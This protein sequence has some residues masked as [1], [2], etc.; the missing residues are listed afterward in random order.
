MR[1]VSIRLLG[2][3]LGGHL[4]WCATAT[5]TLEGLW[6]LDEASGTIA[7]DSS[8]NG[9]DGTSTDITLEATGAHDRSYLF[10]GSTSEVE[11]PALNLNTT[12]F[13]LSAWVHADTIQNDWSALFFCRGGSTVAG[14]SLQD[15]RELGYHWNDDGWSW[16]TGLIVPDNQ[17]VFVAMVIDPT[18]CTIYM[19]D[20]SGLQKSTRTFTHSAQSFDVV[21]YLGYD[22]AGQR[23]FSGQLDEVQIYSR[24]L[25][26]P[27]IQLLNAISSPGAVHFSKT[28]YQELENGGAVTV[29]VQRLLDSAGAISVDYAT[30]NGT[31]TA[32]SD[33][34]ATSG[35]LNWADGDTSE[36]SF[37]VVLLDDTTEL[38]WN[39]TILL[40]LTNP[41]GGAIIAAPSQAQITIEEDD[42]SNGFE[43]VSPTCSVQ[44]YTANAVIYVA[45]LGDGAG[46]ASVEYAT[47]SGTAVSG[48]N[49]LPTQGTLHWA[50]GDLEAKS[51]E[52][53]IPDNTTYQGDFT[54]PIELSSPSL[55]MIL[56]RYPTTTLTILEDDLLPINQGGAQWKHDAYARLDTHR[57]ADFTVIV[58]DA[59]GN[60]IPNATISM[61]M[62]QHEFLFGSEMDPAH[63]LST[64]MSDTN[65]VNF[66]EAAYNSGFNVATFGNTLKWLWY[67]PSQGQEGVDR[68]RS[69]KMQYRGHAVMRPSFERAPPVVKSTY[70]QTLDKV[71]L[72]E[73]V[74]NRVVQAATDFRGQFIHWDVFNEMKK[75]ND[76]SGE[77][78]FNNTYYQWLK[79]MKEHDPYTR[80]YVTETAVIPNDRTQGFDEVFN[81]IKYNLQP[82]E[83][84]P[85][86]SVG[87][88]GHLGD[89]TFR[90]SAASKWYRLQ[91]RADHGAIG[92]WQL[93]FGI[94]EFDYELNSAYTEEDDADDLE[95]WLT[96]VFSHPR[97]EMFMMWGFWDKIHWKG[98]SP[99]YRED[100]SLKPAGQRWLDLVTGKWWTDLDD[101]SSNAQGEVEQRIFK[102]LHYITATYNGSTASGLFSVKEDG[103]T[104]TLT[105]GETDVDEDWLPDTWE[106]AKF[107]NT[108]TAGW[109][110]DANNNGQLEP[111]EFENSDVDQDG[112]TDLEEFQNQTDPMDPQSGSLLRPTIH[113]AGQNLTWPSKRNGLYIVQESSDLQT[114]TTN[115]MLIATPP[116]NSIP[117]ST[118]NTA[119]FYRIESGH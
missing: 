4:A 79:L 55:G 43:F 109:N 99:M 35:T 40:N 75:H 39:E 23:H 84:P 13:T 48:I 104:L 8:G 20:G 93:A 34:V 7:A 57:K 105:L 71:W 53:P 94:T 32:G 51:F 119:K 38:E 114:W 12:T 85:V 72:A 29:Q 24:A 96:L 67:N 92:E 37:Q 100:W 18:T 89:T 6:L 65:V 60:R 117:I 66:Q 118:T 76:L 113:V 11:I 107:G 2:A 10:N 3:L 110:I 31:A 112:F 5:G 58:Q 19:N 17:W 44:E 49:Y 25:T 61:Q 68:L 111:S 91:D 30:S 80:I 115:D 78:G 101:L 106:V 74:S 87:F 62:R 33:Y 108:T 116:F 36:K 82:G 97:A 98:N 103:D 1:S 28:D 90:L 77:L 22:S 47:G 73:Q 95:E 42:I 83:K 27:E 59:Q 46:A 52:V 41:T 26:E 88:Q 9:Y 54:L 15:T 50:D 86:D 70:D 64:D 21:S 14:L 56:V 81:A 63:I 16:S 45:R 102:G 69:Q